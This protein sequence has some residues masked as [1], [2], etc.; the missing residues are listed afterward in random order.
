MIK[1]EDV[2]VFEE[3]FCRNIKVAEGEKEIPV[4]LD[5][6]FAPNID[7]KA[8]DAKLELVLEVGEKE[9]KEFPF[10]YKLKIAGIFSWQSIELTEAER[11][12]SIEGTE[13][14]QSFIRTYFYDIL[15]KANLRAVVLPKFN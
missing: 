10:Y 7:P 13:I 8:N 3:V 15:K 12:I 4:K 2:C 6:N 11:K 5:S 9:S 1:C 14:M